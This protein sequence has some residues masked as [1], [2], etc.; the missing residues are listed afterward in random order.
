MHIRRKQE[1]H[2]QKKEAKKKEKQQKQA[3]KRAREGAERVQLSEEERAAKRA[4]MEKRA[5]QRHEEREAV[6]DRLLEARITA[7][8]LVLD[9]DFWD[10]MPDG[11]Q[12]SLVSQLAF[13]SGC[14]KKSEK[15]CSLHFTRCAVTRQ[16]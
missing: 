2:R 4:A 10:L 11:S 13:S 14:N 16:A 1:M 8:K 7:P 3:E 15:P 12:R 5:K 9:L 6:A